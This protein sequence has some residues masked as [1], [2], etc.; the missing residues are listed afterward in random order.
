M[1]TPEEIAKVITFL[2]SKDASFVNGQTILVDGCS[3]QSYL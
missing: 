2:M 3:T 1:G